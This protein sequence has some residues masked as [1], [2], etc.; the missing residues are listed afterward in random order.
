MNY[1]LVLITTQQLLCS[2]QVYIVKLELQ[3]D[4]SK[5]IY[6]ERGCSLYG[7]LELSYC[8]LIT[9]GGGGEEERSFLRNL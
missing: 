8:F 1:D 6:K 4:P 5:R 3:K 2:L 7:H 9:G